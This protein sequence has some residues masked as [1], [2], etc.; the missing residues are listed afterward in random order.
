MHCVSLNLSVFQVLDARSYF[1]LWTY[2]PCLP[3]WHIKYAKLSIG[4]PNIHNCHIILKHIILC[5]Y[6]IIWVHPITLKT[7]NFVPL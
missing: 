6:K 5:H 4:Q 1:H 3:S 7:Y 2:G